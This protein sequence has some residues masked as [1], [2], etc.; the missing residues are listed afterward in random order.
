MVAWA[1]WTVQAALADYEAPNPAYAPPTHYYDTATG[2]GD[3]LRTKLHTI[4]S[5]SFTGRTYGDFRFASALLDQDP[6]NPSNILLVY[7]RASVPAT[8]DLGHTWNREHLWCV[9]WLGTGDPGNDDSPTVETDEFELRPVSPSL[10]SSRSNNFDGLPTTTGSAGIPAANSAAWYPGNA[11]AGEVARSFFYLATRYYTGSP[12]LSLTNLQLINTSTIPTSGSY[13]GGDLASFLKWNYVHGVDN[14]ER[15]RN[16]YIY[17]SSG[18]LTDHALNPTYYQGNRNPFIDHPEYVWAIFGT[19]KD[20]G[21]NV[22]NNSQLSVSTPDANGISTATVDL[23]RIMTNG[24]FG[25][26]NVTFSKTGPD[27]TTFDITTS[28]SAITL[29]GANKLIAGAGQGIDYNNQTRTITAG[30]NAS[31]STTGFK[32]GFITIHNSDLTSSGAG[33]GS[34]D[35]NDTINISG[36]VLDKRLVTPSLPSVD[37]GTVVIGAAVGS[38]FGL[39]TTGDDGNRTRVNVAGSSTSDPNGVQITGAAALFNSTSSTSSR[40]IGGTLNSIGN[41]SGTL[42]LAVTTAENGGAGLAGEGSYPAISVGY[43]ATVLDHANGSF[44]T[45]SDTDSLSIN[46]GSFVQGTAPQPIAFSVNNLVTTANFTA[47]LDLLNISGT[48]NTSALTT[49]I[50]AF[51]NLAAGSASSFQTSFDTTS[52]GS[53]S[54]TYTLNLSDDSTLLGATP[55]QLTLNLSG[56]VV[57]DFMT[58][59]F[60]RDHQVTASDIHVMMDALTDLHAY[61]TMKGLTDPQLNTVADVNTD[62]SIDNLDAQALLVQLANAPGGGGGL[63]A[64]PEPSGIVLFTLAA[65]AVF[66]RRCRG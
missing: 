50:A 34:A 13:Q 19:D 1:S 14:F 2:T 26:G 65:A 66:A 6:T 47:G 55:Q 41:K 49:N 60:D 59:D 15:R 7:S 36:A 30:L 27:P 32:S 42:S 4:V 22:I 53:F 35:G 57:P 17:G 11:D 12:T 31:T 28:G 56:V 3:V 18:D 5:S 29:S 51:A 61:Q 46:F 43:T 16:Q 20:G 37:F 38:T 25:T 45:P 9:S 40:N 21:G 54:A 48:G 64:V 8:W 39:S 62:G 23:G 58:G 24:S 44:T 10:N 33:H 52:T 63:T